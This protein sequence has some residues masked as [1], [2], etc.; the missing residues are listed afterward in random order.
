M[1]QHSD[2]QDKARLQ[3]TGFLKENRQT[4]H[5]LTK[6]L[7]PKI[8]TD[9]LRIM[10]TAK[11][12]GPEHSHVKQICHELSTSMAEAFEDRT[13]EAFTL[14][15]TDANIFINGQIVKFPEAEFTRSV[16]VRSMFIAQSIN[17]IKFL[18]GVEASE[19]SALVQALSSAEAPKKNQAKKTAKIASL[20]TFDQP[21][22]KLRA[23][24]LRNFENLA[25]E[26]VRSQ[27]VEIYA[28]LMVKCAQYFEQLKTSSNASARFMKRLIQRAT[29]YFADYRHVFIGLIN[30]KVIQHQDFVHAVNTA[31][32]SMFIAQELGLERT[33]LVRIGLT[34][35]TQDV[36]RILH[37]EHEDVQEVGDKSHFKTNMTSVTVLSQ[38]GSTDVVSALRLVTTYERG[39]PYNKPLPHDWYSEEFRPHLLSRLVEIARHYDIL[40]QGLDE[41][42]PLTP[43]L[44]LQTLSQQ[45]GRHYD[46]RLTKLFINVIG[47][48]PVGEM[49]LLSSGEKA[50]V[51][52]SP[53]I[54]QAQS[55]KSIAHRPTVKL[56]NGSNQLI[57]LAIESNHNIHIVEIVE[58]TEDEQHP[59]AFFFF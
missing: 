51:V 20:E 21:H 28:G 42:T 16:M 47:I 48:Y 8:I 24:S 6:V 38:M 13:E 43:D 30:L 31:L 27:I 45:M 11:I 29:D 59:G 26:D 22:I 23:V 17:Q 46:P 52:K 40:I 33:E 9:I 49:V 2:T 1:S 37:Q 10:H 18:K 4:D 50:I 53:N 34:A 3:A 35:I 39:F 12:F 5:T 41:N 54:T 19:W 44:A 32:Y 55:N 57:D 14:Q 56:L 36:D 25:T 58:A 7:G 15:F